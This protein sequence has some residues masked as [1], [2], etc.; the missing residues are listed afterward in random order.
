MS[1]WFRPAGSSGDADFDVRITPG[2]P[3]WAHTG[4]YAA[5]LQP[6]ESRTIDTGD[7][8]WI[9]LPLSGGGAVVE[10]GER[11]FTLEGRPDVFAGPTDLVYVPRDSRFTVSSTRGGRIAFPFAKARRVFPVDEDRAGVETHLEEIYYVELRPVRS[12]VGGAAGEQQAGIAYLRNYG[13]DDAPIDT[14]EEVR[15]GD[16]VLIP[17]GWHGPA[18]APPGYDLYYLNV[19]AGPG[20]TRAWLICDDPAHAWVRGTWPD[21][22]VDSRLPFAGR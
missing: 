2:D 6:G 20:Q 21:Q 7:C 10:V 8:E 16:V 19:M 9:V 17:H 14:L 11:S 4:L 15:S 5:T 1:D 22:P 18:M 13:T 12:V 3:G